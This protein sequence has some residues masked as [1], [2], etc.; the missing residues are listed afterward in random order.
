MLLRR[1]LPSLH[2]QILRPP[3]LGPQIRLRNL[4]CPQIHLRNLPPLLPTDERDVRL[5]PRL[6]PLQEAGLVLGI[7]IQ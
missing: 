1:Y 7:N 5:V 6:E 4:A 3:L 2:Q